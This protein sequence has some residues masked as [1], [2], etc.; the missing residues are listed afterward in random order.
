MHAGEYYKKWN[1]S[2]K[3]TGAQRVVRPL[4]LLARG[5]VVAFRG[6]TLEVVGVVL[7]AEQRGR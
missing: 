4:E 7:V 3:R 6:D 2:E 5:K 1:K